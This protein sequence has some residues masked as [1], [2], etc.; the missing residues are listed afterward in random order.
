VRE[1]K[2]QDSVTRGIKKSLEKCLVVTQLGKE[3]VDGM[4]QGHGRKERKR[5]A[6]QDEVGRLGEWM[7][8]INDVGD[9]EGKSP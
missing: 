6:V 8:E 4:D 3:V 5:N 7:T 9:R 1:V 2:K